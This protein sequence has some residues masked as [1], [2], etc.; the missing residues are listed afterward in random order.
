MSVVKKSLDM[1]EEAC[2]ES[3]LASSDLSV[4]SRSTMLSA[5]IILVNLAREGFCV[6]SF[7]SNA[8]MSREY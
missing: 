6:S 3:P 8:S 2:F 7:L 5:S 4:F 1:Q